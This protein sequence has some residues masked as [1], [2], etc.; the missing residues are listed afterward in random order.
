[1]NVDAA[2]WGFELM[3]EVTVELPDRVADEIARRATALGT[4]PERWVTAMVEDVIADLPAEGH[5]G[6]DSWICR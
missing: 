3:T 2:C 1:M 4:T 5:D 6:P